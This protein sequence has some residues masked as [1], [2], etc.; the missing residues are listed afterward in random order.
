MTSLAFVFGV[1]PMAVSSGA[2]SGGQHAVGTGVMGDDF[3][4]HSGNLLRTAILCAGTSPLPA[5]T[6][7][8]INNKKGDM[9]TC[10]LF[11]LSDKEPVH[12]VLSFYLCPRNYLRSITSIKSFQFP[13]SR[14]I[15]TT[16][17][18]IMGILRKQYTVVKLIYSIAVI[19]TSGAKPM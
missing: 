1:L 15:I 12:Q 5:E 18:I 4:Y 17:L 6:P 2:G 13:S 7:A 10:R 3:R 16:S 14:S 8:G 9:P 19:T 11:Q